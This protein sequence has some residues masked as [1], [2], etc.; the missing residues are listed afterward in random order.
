MTSSAATRHAAVAAEDVGASRPATQKTGAA[1]G[2]FSS[3]D[4]L[5]GLIGLLL[6]R[7]FSPSRPLQPPEHRTPATHRRN[8]DLSRDSRVAVHERSALNGVPSA[9]RPFETSQSQESLHRHFHA[10]HAVNLAA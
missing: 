3:A 4:A 9:T 2:A 7:K 5:L 8:R 10:L 6:R 1:S